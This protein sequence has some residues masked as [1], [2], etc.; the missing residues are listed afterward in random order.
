MATRLTDLMVRGLIFGQVLLIALVATT[1]LG[2]TVGALDRRAPFAVLPHEPV[3]VQAGHWSSISVPVYRDLSRRCD[4]SYS[5]FLF[6]SAN[7]RVDLSSGFVPWEQIQ[8]MDDRTPGRL[9]I[10]IPVP[11]IEAPGVKGGIKPGPGRLASD[12]EYVC[13]KGHVL[14]PVKVHTDILLDIQP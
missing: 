3:L 2:L 7:S 11:P 14:F 10:T 5:R 13:N 6:D 9:L 1:V 4:A 12:L 8:A